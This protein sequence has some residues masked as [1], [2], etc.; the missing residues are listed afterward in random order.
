MMQTWTNRKKE[1]RRP[2]Y[3]CVWRRAQVPPD[4]HLSLLHPGLGRGKGGQLSSRA[5]HDPGHGTPHAP[6]QPWQALLPP[7]GLQGTQE[8]LWGEGMGVTGQ[9]LPVQE[10]VQPTQPT[11]PTQ[12]GEL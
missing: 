9:P 12:L 7:D 5:D 11:Q 10:P 8:A 4:P 3:S 2:S 6:P 1:G